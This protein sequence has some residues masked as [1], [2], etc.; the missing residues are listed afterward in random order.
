MPEMEDVFP[1]LVTLVVEVSIGHLA[2]VPSW[3]FTHCPELQKL[4]LVVPSCVQDAVL[5]LH[6][7]DGQ[8][9]TVQATLIEL[10]LMTIDCFIARG[11]MITE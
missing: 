9:R 5:A 6:L 7:V 2:E 3:P 10:P 11:V 4:T 8:A 1:K